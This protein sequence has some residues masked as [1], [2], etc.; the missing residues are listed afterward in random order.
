M[1]KPKSTTKRAR[2]IIRNEIHHFYG[3]QVTNTRRNPLDV[4]REDADNYNAGRLPREK[5]SDWQK[6]TGLVDA[7]CF[8]IYRD[9]QASV[10][11]KIFGKEKVAKWS[12][13]KCH[14]VYGSLIGRE[15]AAMLRRK[16]KPPKG[17]KK[18]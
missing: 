7:G 16:K 4:M 6:G 5:L 18:R 8:R 11:E 13:T 2:S 9:D 1:F 10:L 12:G 17:R 14:Q 15:Y 3:N